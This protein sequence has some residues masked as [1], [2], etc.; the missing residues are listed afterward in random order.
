MHCILLASWRLSAFSYIDSIHLTVGCIHLAVDC[1]HLDVKSI[2]LALDCL[3]LAVAY[4]QWQG[5]ATIDSKGGRKKL[6]I[7]EQFLA[8]CA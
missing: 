8:V 2:Y 4:I 6:S 5:K 1:I 3:G 7:T